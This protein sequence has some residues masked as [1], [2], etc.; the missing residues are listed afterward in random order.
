MEE[1]DNFSVEDELI[2]PFVECR[3]RMEHPLVPNNISRWEAGFNL[4]I[5]E[6]PRLLAT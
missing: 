4:D 6:V 3:A 2:N 5:T 1:D